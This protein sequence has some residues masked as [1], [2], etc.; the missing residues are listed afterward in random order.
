[1]KI[2]CVSLDKKLRKTE[3]D[4]GLRKEL[5][6]PTPALNVPEPNEETGKRLDLL[7]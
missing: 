1:M 3:D 2:N 5:R 4:G 7:A 6:D